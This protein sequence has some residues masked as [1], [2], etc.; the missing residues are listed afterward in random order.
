MEKM[1][2]AALLLLLPA[3]QGPDCAPLPESAK[4]SLLSSLRHTTD[5]L[6]STA[7]Q[8]R[9]MSGLIGYIFARAHD[10]TAAQE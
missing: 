5:G 8:I 2:L 1:T 10:S 6:V 9:F 7:S 4:R 3:V